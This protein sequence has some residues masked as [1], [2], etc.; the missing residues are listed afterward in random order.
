MRLSSVFCICLALLSSCAEQ[1]IQETNN[2]DG[3][4]VKPPIFL[5]D[6]C[7]PGG[8]YT[9]DCPDGRDGLKWCGWDGLS[10]SD[11]KMCSIGGQTLIEPVVMCMYDEDCPGERLACTS[12]KCDGQRCYIGY[13][14]PGLGPGYAEEDEPNNCHRLVCN[15]EHELESV[16]DQHD[17]DGTCDWNGVC[18]N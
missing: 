1:Q 16:P 12:P 18:Q 7:E 10:M 9:C 6:T 15:D 4:T 14:W 8:M 5:I 2:Q 13:V 11:C 3:G 17:C